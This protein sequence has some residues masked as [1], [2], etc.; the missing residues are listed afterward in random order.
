MQTIRIETWINAPLDRCFDAARDLDLHMKSVSHT[1][2]RAVRGRTS[3]LIEAG[4]EVT[5]QARH[6]GIAQEFTSRI[7]TFQRGNF[8]QPA[9]IDLTWTSKPTRF[10][11]VQSDTILGALPFA[12]LLD[13]PSAG[14]NNAAF[15]DFNANSFYRIRAFRPL[16]P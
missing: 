13:L 6:F 11:A 9:R 5:W 16:T 8:G 7:T 14:A 1:G 2:E 15:L 4:E 12:D 10:Y 3:G